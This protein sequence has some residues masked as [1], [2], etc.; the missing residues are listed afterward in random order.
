MTREFIGLIFI[1]FLAKS[2]GQVNS[3]PDRNAFINQS[4][5]NQLIAFPACLSNPAFS[6]LTT[7]ESLGDLFRRKLQEEENKLTPSSSP[8]NLFNTGKF[9]SL[10]V[11]SVDDKFKDYSR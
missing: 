5:A 10:P 4:P 3:L 9:L 2:A 7:P 6:S 1:L 11:I 8:V